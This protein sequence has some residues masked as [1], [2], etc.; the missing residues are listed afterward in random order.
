[1]ANSGPNTTNPHDPNRTP[2]GS[3]TGSAAAV[4]DLQVPLS[5][6]SQSGGSIIRPAAFTGIF[7]MKPTINKISLEG[8]KVVS[9]NFDT[10]GFFSRSVEDLQLVADLFAFQEYDGLHRQSLSQNLPGQSRVAMI[11]TPMWDLAGPGTRS[12]MTR[13]TQILTKHGVQVE[14]LDLPAH[15]GN[16]EALRLLHKTV[17]N[18]EAQAALLV[19]YRKDKSQLSKIIRELVENTGN[20]TPGD[21]KRAID[22]YAAMRPEFDRVAEQYSAIITPSADDV[23]PIGLGDMGDSGF[24]FLWTASFLW[25]HIT[26]FAD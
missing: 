14:E 17:L 2:G 25:S 19:E 8:V 13:A 20:F 9:F 15:W 10:C 24:Q 26:S 23:A 6:G 7:A 4:A 16:A 11:K 5:F 22:R 12:A 1:M 3:S 21:I 18:G